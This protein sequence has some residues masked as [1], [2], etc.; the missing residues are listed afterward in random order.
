VYIHEKI[1]SETQ[2]KESISFEKRIL[3]DGLTEIAARLK[4]FEKT[5]IRLT[6]ASYNSTDASYNS[7]V[8]KINR[9]FEKELSY[10]EI[11]ECLKHNNFSDRFFSLV[12]VTN[13]KKQISFLEALR[14]TNTKKK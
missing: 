13:T 14:T 1:H 3:R 11:I 2:L 5:G 9:G 8:A 4:T 12:G 10:S 7:I 6:D